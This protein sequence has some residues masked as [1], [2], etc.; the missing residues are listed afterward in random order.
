MLCCSRVLP[1]LLGEERRPDSRK[2][3]KSSLGN[4]RNNVFQ[5]AMQQC[6]ET[7]W[8]KMLP[9][10][11]NLYEKTDEQ[12]LNCFTYPEPFWLRCS[13]VHMRRK[14]V[15]DSWYSTN[16][17]LTVG[18]VHQTL[19]L[20]KQKQTSALCVMNGER[21]TGNTSNRLWTCLLQQIRLEHFE[22]ISSMSIS[23]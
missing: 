9:V 20:C 19:T 4:M 5:H 22:I 21:L 17:R 23:T 2:R 13:D 7:S 12:W 10:L 11:P 14:M 1:S 6:C 8:R 18:D 16:N 3:R 15:T